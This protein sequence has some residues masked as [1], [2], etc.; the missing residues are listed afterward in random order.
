M[1]N[2]RGRILLIGSVLWAFGEG[3]LGPLFAVF[4]QKI[5]GSVLDITSA[6]AVFLAVTGISII[7]VGKISDSLNHN[8]ARERI[9]V[10]G[11]G[12]NAFCTFGYIFVTTP[13][14]LL[15]V[16]LGLGLTV[17]LSSPTWLS[18]Y[19]D[20]NKKNANAFTWGLESG[21]SYIIHAISILIG[22]YIVTRYSFNALFAM[23]GVIQVVATIY[24]ARIL[25]L[26]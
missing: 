1:L 14:H 15:F 18:L 19:A 24:Q 17:A 6:W 26:R 10:T 2:K 21:L 8:Y 4:T 3:M 25:K 9:L 16:Q 5:G 12:L 13:T 7:L 22:G 23:M 20:S 11:Y